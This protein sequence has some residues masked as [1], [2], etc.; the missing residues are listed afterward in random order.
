MSLLNWIFDIYQHGELDKAREDAAHARSEVAAIKSS[1][2]GVD[3]ARLEHVLGE[4]ALATRTLRRMLVQ[5]GVCTPR[6]FAALLEEVD[7]EDGRRDG[8]SPIG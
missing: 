4:L 7:L 6:E 5:K 2:G 8:K 3:A 1:A